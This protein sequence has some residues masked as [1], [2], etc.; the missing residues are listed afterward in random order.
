MNGSNFMHWWMNLVGS[1]ATIALI[2][3]ALEIMLCIV[4][5]EDALRRVGAILGIVIL[6]VFI[7]GVLVSA[8]SCMTLW[9]KI[10]LVAIGAA[11]WQ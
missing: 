4:K 7:Q 8:W 1:F 3:K 9:E 5:P 6:L 10:G 11:V 2:L